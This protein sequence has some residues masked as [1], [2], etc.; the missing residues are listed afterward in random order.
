M[1]K[2]IVLVTLCYTTA[3]LVVLGFV[4]N[5]L[6]DSL[7][8]EGSV[9]VPTLVFSIPVVLVVAVMAYRREN[10]WLTVALVAIILGS[11]WYVAKTH[12]D[13]YGEWLPSLASAEVE[14]SGTAKLNTHGQDLLYRLELHNPGAITHRE[15]LVVTRGGT[16]QRIRIPIFD[17]ARSGYVS[18]KTPNDWIVLHP[19]ADAKVYRAEIGRFLF[20][21]KSFQVNLQTRAVKTIATKPSG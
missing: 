12:H 17:D 16:D 18:A 6:R 8:F 15:Y 20:V 21:Q 13:A 9:I 10:E 2:F 11:G 19:T 3:A 7:S 4:S 1:R 14:T 5:W